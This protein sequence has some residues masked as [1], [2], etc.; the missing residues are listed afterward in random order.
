[1]PDPEERFIAAATAPLVDN[2]ELQVR[3]AQQLQDAIAARVAS[4]PAAC[5]SLDQCAAR[6]EGPRPK[7]RFLMPVILVA[8]LAL[9]ASTMLDFYR[10]REMARYLF[11]G[12]RNREALMADA[13]VPDATPQ[14]RLLLSGDPSLGDPVT[15]WGKLWDSAPDNPAYF[16]RY[17]RAYVKEVSMVPPNFRKAAERLDPNNGYFPLLE[18]TALAKKHCVE[19]VRVTRQK[20]DPPSAPKWKI[21]D[22]ERL[23]ECLELVT[24]AADLPKCQSYEKEFYREQFALLPEAK[25]SLTSVAIRTQFDRTAAPVSRLGE[26]FAAAAEQL[27]V[28]GDR[29]G[30][31]ELLRIWRHTSSA[32]L[33]SMPDHPLSL[34]TG[35]VVIS[36][37]M[38]NFV[39]AAR[40][41]G[42]TETA[43]KLEAQQRSLRSVRD[44]KGQSTAARKDQLRLHGS[45][46]LTFGEFMEGNRGDDAVAATQA[47]LEPGRR[48]DFE[49]VY[50][51][52]MVVAW[53]IIAIACL[54][55]VLCRFRGGRLPRR[56]SQR[57]TGLLTTA[58]WLW[59]IGGGV[60]VPLLGWQLLSRF[61]PLGAKDWSASLHRMM[62]PTGQLLAC[63]ILML[64]LPLVIARWRLQRRTGRILPLLR[65]PWIGV[66]CMAATA[67]AIPLFWAALRANLPE[68]MFKEKEGDI[69]AI[70]LDVPRF[71]DLDITKTARPAKGFLY[72]ATGL[73]ALGLAWLLAVALRA[74]AGSREKALARTTTSRVLTT[75][76]STAL[77]LTAL[78]MPL[79]H[80]AEQHW[81]ARDELSP[82]TM[83]SAPVTRHEA[84]SAADLRKQLLEILHQEP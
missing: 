5:D 40:E 29:E 30:F 34:Y 43:D 67:L 79:L 83:D 11:S 22:Q 82:I 56:L 4:A 54:L 26:V 24:E 9:A 61:T 64:G 39:P 77:L 65:R 18:A 55:V 81:V 74:L 76:Y 46:F 27:A 45:Y 52:G 42:L 51:A 62:V 80:L 41:L 25:D 7:S 32:W 28:E 2:A 57:M 3:A 63:L 35:T 23:D 20:G 73:I 75:S 21:L 84:Q 13:L 10:H 71:L 19:R 12:T 78:A 69:V 47:D 17:A 14:Q 49:L 68:M 59:I 33:S 58:D 16:A 6:L 60:F 8:A 50:R 1:M 37:P 44:N 66:V 15:G 72:A 48:A 36:V 70:M 53:V 31:E 38:A